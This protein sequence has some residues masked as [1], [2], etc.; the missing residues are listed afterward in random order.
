MYVNFKIRVSHLIV[1]VVLLSSMLWAG[2]VLAGEP[3]SSG[4]PNATSSYSLADLYQRLNVGTVGTSSFFTEP[5]SAPGTDTMH[6]IN[7]IMAKAPA[8]DNTNGATP[9]HVLA[10]QTFWGLTSGEWGLQTG[11]LTSA[12]PPC[13]D[14]TDRYVDCG[15]GTVHDQVTNLI[16]LKNANCFGQLYYAAANNA[17]AG[18]ENGECS[19]TDGSSPGDWR[20]PTKSEWEATI[21]H[22]DV[23]NCTDPNLTDT[24]GTACYNAGGRLKPFTSV[25]Q[26]S[27]YWSSS[28]Y[29]YGASTAWVVYM[30][31]GDVGYANKA[32]SYYV[33]PVRGGQ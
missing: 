30:S 18:L 23:L 15:N 9:T 16:W 33:W 24:E 31:N 27:V 26:S 1:G 10:G 22:A 12:D 7:E 19:L 17:A 29:A 20:L 14:N 3:D 6:T 5:T 25:Q 11:M 32:N 21:A 2:I 4:E 13:W 28:T 8:L